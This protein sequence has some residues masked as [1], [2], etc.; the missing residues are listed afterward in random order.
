MSLPPAY[1][2]DAEGKKLIKVKDI[3]I[4]GLAYDPYDF[5]Y[6]GTILGYGNGPFKNGAIVQ[7]GYGT[8]GFNGRVFDTVVH[9]DTPLTKGVQWY[10]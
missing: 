8:L 3:K 1:S 4:N 5:D 6:D 10:A 2:S 7:A 9:L